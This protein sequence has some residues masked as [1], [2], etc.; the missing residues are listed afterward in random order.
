M[1]IIVDKMK[2]QI[3]VVEDDDSLREWICDYLSSQGY[4]ITSADSGE[5]AIALIKNDNPDLVVLDVMLPEKDGFEV[6]R[7]VRA[8]FNKPI[9]MLT[10]KT[11]EFDEVLGLELGADD[12]LAKPVKPRVLLSRIKVQLRRQYSS[13]N[14]QVVTIGC[15]SISASSRTV[16]LAESRIDVTTNEFEALWMLASKADSIVSRDALMQHIRGLEY[17]GANRSVDIMISRLR[18]KLNDDPSNPTRIKSVRG[19]GYLFATDAW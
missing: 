2:P 4:E 5:E 6:C 19:K 10:A 16:N 14:K 13:A 12:Y 15:F 17:D 7:E 1:T 9:L 11:E 18:K 8:F 3:L